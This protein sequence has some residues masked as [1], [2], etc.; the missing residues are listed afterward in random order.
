MR[1]HVRLA[2]LLAAFAALPAAAVNTE[3]YQIPYF[4]GGVGYLATDSVRNADS[5]QGYQLAFGVPLRNPVNAIEIRFFDYAYKRFDDEDNFQTGLFVDYVRDF[6]SGR[7]G[8]FLSGVRPFGSA[9]VGFVEEDTFANKHLHFGANLGGGAIFPIGFKGWAL[10]LDGRVQAQANDESCKGRG[11]PSFCEDAADYL[12]DYQVSVGLQLPLTIFFDR[13][14]PVDAADD[15]PVAVVDPMTGRRDCAQ[16]SDRDG[17]GDPADQCPG[18]PSGTPVDKQ[19]CPRVKPTTDADSDGVTNDLDKCPGTQEG[20]KVDGT[21]C[22]VAQRTS[23]GGVTFDPDSA[24]L[25]AQGRATLDGVA[26]TLKGQRSLQVEIAGHTDSVGSDAYNTLLSQQRADAVRSY[27][28]E[29]GVEESR[30]AAVGYGEAE[31]VAS[32]DTEDGRVANR[33]VEFRITTG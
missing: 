2:A 27:L 8:G 1:S 10:R 11:A 5:G 17:I 6:H 22:V 18:T 31:P 13:P 9:G 14:V 24:R 4:V 26:A 19:G 15:C 7:G 16:D 23:L 33:R 28:V 32:N 25:T 29:K 12:V 20:L 21:G 30:L 3:N